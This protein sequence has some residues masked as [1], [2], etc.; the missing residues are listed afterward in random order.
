[1]RTPSR[2]I[3]FL[4]LAVS[5]SA[6]LVW[7]SVSQAAND[8]DAVTQP[9]VVI[10]IDDIGNSYEQGLA[11]IN[12]PGPVTYAVLPF[13]AHGKEL[14]ELAHEKG[15][16]LMLHAPM[17]NT[18]HLRLGPG[19]LTDALSEHEFKRVLNASLDAVPFA[20]GLN[21]H[22]GSSLTQKE[23]PMRW[24]MQVAKQRGLFFV[25]SRTTAK[26]IAWEVATAAGVPTFKRDIF[27]D[28]LQTREFLQAQFFKAIRIARQY[29]QAILIGHPYPITT[30]FLAEAIPVLD[31]AGVQLISASALLMVQHELH[32]F[33]QTQHSDCDSTE[34]HDCS[35]E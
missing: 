9:R 16:E 5:L 13:S 32:A 15:K 7:A 11:A 20:I 14:A 34:G 21:N 28:H 8:A 24:V 25:D 18:H 23:L 35:M 33:A 4:C 31:E 12:L 10:I 30:E 17:S 29:G 6:F 27:L 2:F 1:M 3:H 26:S 19:A 22:M